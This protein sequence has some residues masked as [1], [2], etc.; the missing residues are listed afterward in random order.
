MRP[1]LGCYVRIHGSGADASILERAIG[2]AFDAIAAV[3]RITSF[4]RPDSELHR[5]HRLGVGKTLAI[6]PALW[7]VLDFASRLWRDSEGLFDPAVAAVLVAEG[8]LPRPEG[9][10][11]PAPKADLQAL[12]LPAPGLARLREPLWLDLGGVAKGQAVDA[13]LAALRAG[14]ASSGSVNAG[15]DLACFGM[16]ETVGLRDPQD[17]ALITCQ[18]Q[19]RDG[20]LASS[21]DYFRPGVLRR[22]GAQRPASRNDSIAVLAVDCLTADALTKPV[23]LAPQRALRLLERYDAAALILDPGCPPRWIRLPNADG[24]SASPP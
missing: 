20:A 14:G 18:L 6:D 19:L 3:E 16:P 7:R 12:E 1:A 15:G 17:P 24:P 13:A 8:L 23:W 4:H 21:G 9:L 22:A 10:P 2:A 5:L 11:A